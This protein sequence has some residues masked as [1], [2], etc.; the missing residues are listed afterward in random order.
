MDEDTNRAVI[1]KLEL[2]ADTK[3]QFGANQAA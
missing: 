3:K 1:P 2:V